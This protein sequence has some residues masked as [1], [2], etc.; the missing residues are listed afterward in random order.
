MKPLTPEQQR[1]FRK[2]LEASSKKWKRTKLELV[3]AAHASEDHGLMPEYLWPD[4][5]MDAWFHRKSNASTIIEKRGGFSHEVANMALTDPD[6]ET[7]HTVAL[8][9]RRELSQL[10]AAEAEPG[11]APVRRS[12]AMSRIEIADLAIELLDSLNH[13]V[14]ETLICLFQEL[15]DVDRHRRSLAADFSQIAKAAEFEAQIQ[16]QEL[17][18]G[19]RKFAACLSVAPNTVTRWRRSKFYRERVEMSRS[20]WSHVLRDD[21][22]EKIKADVPNAT[23]AECFRRAFAMYGKSLPQRRAGKP[24]MDKD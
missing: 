13:C 10:R 11:K 4:I 8:W 17:P 2:R 15:L 9:L 6:W 19:V 20:C 21:Y 23:E 3:K 18:Y 22:F 24:L 1:E 5:T 12:K 16:L 14:G 7:K